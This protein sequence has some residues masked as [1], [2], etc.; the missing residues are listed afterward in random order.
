MTPEDEHGK[1]AE[2]RS[3]TKPETASESGEGQ[4]E[5]QPVPL[6]KRT[7]F[8]LVLGM[9]LGVLLMLLL[10]RCQ[11]VQPV[12][13]QRE[14]LVSPQELLDL[15]RE[16]TRSLEAELRRLEEALLRDPCELVD[17][18]RTSP[19]QM[20]LPPGAA[21]PS[22]NGTRAVPPVNGTSP[23]SGKLEPIQANPPSTV[24]ELME[25][26]TVFVLSVGEE[27]AGSGTGFFVAPG[28]VATNRHVVMSRDNKVIVG[29]KQ[30]GR[31]YL[32][33][34]I[35]LSDESSGDYALLRVP[36]AVGKTP[37][38][39]I[40]DTAKRTERISSWGFPG[41]I[42]DADPKYAALL[43][44]DLT[45]VPEVVYS[46]GVVSVVLDRKPPFI[47]HTSQISQGNSGGPLIDSQGTVLGINTLIR[48]ADQ[49]NAQANIA[50]PGSELKKF[51]RANGVTP[52]APGN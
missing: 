35:A 8:W 25:Q 37:V 21:V 16:Y 43:E 36:E 29:N 44:G 5:K 31:M 14:A 28:V 48:V 17:F 24:G 52:T 23:Q 18:S 4:A 15:Q 41:L 40:N 27:A 51:M 45:A 10:A 32:A 13:Q 30:L 20:P 19:E 11:P 6:H 7:A 12:T 47:M 22:T 1:A 9:L 3:S 38:L 42:T 34:V 39:S 50:L 49:S 33:D 2:T 46:E 26:A